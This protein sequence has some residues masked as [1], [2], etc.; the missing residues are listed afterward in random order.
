MLTCC[1]GERRTTGE[2]KSKNLEGKFRTLSL[3]TS[4]SK[5]ILNCQLLWGAHA[6]VLRW[7]SL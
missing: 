3:V 1:H 6:N 7:H 4:Q 5:K 2:K